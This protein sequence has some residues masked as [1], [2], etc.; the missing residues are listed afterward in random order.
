MRGIKPEIEVRSDRIK[1]YYGQ[2]D[3]G[4]RVV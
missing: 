1:R 3:E 4:L 2:L